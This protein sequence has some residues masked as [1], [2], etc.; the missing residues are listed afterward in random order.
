MRQPQNKPALREVKAR[1]P[2]WFSLANKRFFNDRE[3]FVYYS[4]SG[5]PYLVRSTY[6]WSDMFGQP[7]TLKYKINELA[8][9][10]EIRPLVDEDFKDLEAV[11]FWLR[12]H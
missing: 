7:K 4:F 8:D 2:G 6:A 5:Q 12:L 9:D 1:Q 3:Y 10:W 11:K